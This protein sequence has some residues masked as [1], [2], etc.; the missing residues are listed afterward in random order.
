[1]RR[2]VIFVR[3]GQLGNQ[4]IRFMFA[5]KLSY[6]AGGLEIAGYNMPEWGL[7]STELQPPRGRCVRTGPGQRI[8]VGALAGILKSGLVDWVD[9]DGH[10]QRLEYFDDE[11]E[12]FAR[13]FSSSVAGETLADDDIAI[14][15]RAG[16]I[17]DGSHGDYM[18]L[19]IAFYRRL[20]DE[21]GY[22]PVFV[23][24]VSGNFYT[25]ALRRRFAHARFV[26]GADRLSDFQTL[27][28]ARNIAIAVSTFSWLA[29]YFSPTAQVI[30]FPVL[31]LLN[32]SQRPD[33]DLMPSNDRR[34]VFHPFPVQHYT[35]SPQQ[36]AALVA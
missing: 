2:P 7:V 35:G 22:R 28:K 26:G 27:R 32:P 13:L 8:E 16:D 30:H 10:A 23:G 19:P 24:E 21:T 14:H 18:P 36:K 9:I 31:G 6:R 3:Q 20:I 34:Y 33:I 11:K 12:S 15:V 1:M 17:V 4:M 5:R 29:A 25:D